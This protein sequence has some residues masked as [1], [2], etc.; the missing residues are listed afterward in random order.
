MHTRS[1]NVGS[2]APCR[3]P[4]LG[5]DGAP[6]QSLQP[7][8]D[9]TSWSQLWAGEGTT[10][11]HM[12]FLSNL[13]RYL[14]KAI[15]VPF[16]QQSLCC[17]STATRSGSNKAR[18]NFITK[19]G[20][21]NGW[22]VPCEK[23]GNNQSLR[24][25]HKWRLYANAYTEHTTQRHYGRRLNLLTRPS[26]YWGWGRTQRFLT[27]W[28]GRCSFSFTHPSWDSSKAAS[29]A[30]SYSFPSGSLRESS[31]GLVPVLESGLL[32]VYCS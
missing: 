2:F 29:A 14:H 27:P 5:K 7:W 1:R 23:P 11:L 17:Q 20:E 26:H 3:I 22:Q 24:Y 28:P 18:Y 15:W 31:W 21:D 30:A 12:A 4:P 32:L 10:Q 9:E 6:Q 13:L 19:D 25:L 8:T 16:S